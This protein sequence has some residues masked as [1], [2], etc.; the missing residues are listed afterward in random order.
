LVA[1]AVRVA[2]DIPDIDEVVVSSDDE[3][4]LAEARACGAVPE[5]RPDALAQDDT[6]T[7]EVV[8][9]FLARRP[10]VEAL[11]LL[12]PTS[13][14]RATTDVQTCLD[15]LTTADS[16]ATVT[17]CEHPPEWS[18]RLTEE[19]RLHPVLGWDAVTARRQDA[20]P[21]YRLNGA[22]YAVRAQRIRDGA[23]LVGP[24]T[25]AVV[26][27]LERSI[28]VDDELDLALASLVADRP[29]PGGSPSAGS[30]S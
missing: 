1:R 27:P 25:T 19:G 15:V 22:V 9:D 2:L 28:D 12:Q 18:F 24:D 5:R 11:V 20:A 16:V 13:P 30:G 3:D 6:P 21:A 26:M 17:G 14:L 7:L 29:G 23:G 4:V 10:E 8:Q